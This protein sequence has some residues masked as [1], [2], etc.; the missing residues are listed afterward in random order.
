MTFASYL[1]A[2]VLGLAQPAERILFIGNS[3]TYVNDLPAMVSALAKADWRTIHCEMV[4]RPDFSLE[5]HWQQG[6]ARRAIR[7]GSWTTVVLQQGPS[8]L[9]ESRRLLIEYTRRF[10]QEIKAAGAR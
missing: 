10:D 1:L 9:P 3:L 8:A 6:E 5:D 7:S 4:A 2:A